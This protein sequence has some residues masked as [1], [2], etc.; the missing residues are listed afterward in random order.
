[1]FHYQFDWGIITSG[2]VFRVAAVGILYHG[3]TLRGVYR[4]G[5][6]AGSNHRNDADE[7][8]L[9]GSLVCSRVPGILPQHSAPGAN[10]LLVFRFL[11]GAPASGQRLV[12]HNELRVRRGGHS[13][14]DLYIRIY[15]RGHPIRNPFSP[16]GAD[17]GRSQFRFFVFPVNAIHY[18][19][20]SH[21]NHHSTHSSISSSI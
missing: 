5:L 17:G 12:G 13:P 16:Q 18:L 15:C 20:A 9:A 19:A 4:S 11:Q 1:M 3:A 7:P 10:V 2:K 14:D 6:P 21:Q 8:C